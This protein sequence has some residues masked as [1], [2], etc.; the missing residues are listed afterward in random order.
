MN[1]DKI[2]REQMKERFSQIEE[3][4]EG[5]SACRRIPAYRE[6]F[7]N[8]VQSCTIFWL[9]QEDGRAVG[10]AGSS[11]RGDLLFLIPDSEEA[12][13]ELLKEA[14]AFAVRQRS[15]KIHVVVPSELFLPMEKKKYKLSEGSQDSETGFVNMEKKL[16]S[17]FSAK[18][19][20][21]EKLNAESW[22]AVAIV[23]VILICIVLIL[24]RII[25]AV[26]GIL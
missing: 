18:P 11:D 2:L 19:D 4:L 6:L 20:T 26:T 25:Q 17:L 3:F 7:I 13:R 14:E 24:S 21:G 8:R 9:A 15:E 22:S 16:T 1:V 10:L 5:S 23:T 12:C